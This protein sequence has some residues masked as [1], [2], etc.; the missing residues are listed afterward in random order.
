MKALIRN[1]EVWKIPETMS[2]GEVLWQSS[3]FP[4]GN[5]YALAQDAPEDAI[6]ADFDISE[7]TETMP[8]EDP[9][10]EPEEIIHLVAVLNRGRYEARKAAE[11]EFI[12]EEADEE[13]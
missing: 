10:G 3:K 4:R 9:E 2:E 5:S 8:A 11:P 1:I 6:A 12:P 13:A 7:K